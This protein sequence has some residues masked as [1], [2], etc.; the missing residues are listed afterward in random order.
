MKVAINT[1]SLQRGGFSLSKEAYEFL[2]L[3]WDGHGCAFSDDSKR[4]DPKLIECI[5]AIGEKADGSCAEISIVEVPDGV[6]WYIH[7][8]HGQETVHERHQRWNVWQ[9][10]CGDN[11]RL[12]AE[13]EVESV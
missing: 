6:Q 13:R 5:E 10:M 12:E 2:G 3:E 4:T 11:K 7:D 8:F 1:C 9:S